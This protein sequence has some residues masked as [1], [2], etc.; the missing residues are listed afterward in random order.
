MY[1]AWIFWIAFVYNYVI[2]LY[3]LHM[4]DNIAYYHIIVSRWG[5]SN[6][7]LR[8]YLIETSRCSRGVHL[9]CALEID[10][11]F[12]LEKCKIVLDL[13]SC[14]AELALNTVLLIKTP[15]GYLVCWCP[16]PFLKWSVL[17]R[18]HFATIWGMLNL[19]WP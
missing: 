6:S 1:K 2:M 10:P 12:Y 14:P 11:W 16:L 19:Q 17:Q 4:S 18:R 5:K 8:I 15:T 13:G 9:I 7:L 3:D